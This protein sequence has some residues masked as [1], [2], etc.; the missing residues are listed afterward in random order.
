MCMRRK[1]PAIVVLL[2]GLLPSA[3]H[4]QAVR[5]IQPVCQKAFGADL[6]VSGKMSGVRVVEID[7]LVPM[8]AITSVPKQTEM[9]WPPPE[10]AVVALPAELS[11]ATGIQS[12]TFYWES[13]GHPPAPFMTPHFDFHFN[14][15]SESD[16]KSL[17]CSD[18][19]KPAKLPAGYALT[20]DTVPDIGVLVGTCVPL[21][22]MHALAMK[23]QPTPFTAT[24]VLGYYH[25]R[26]IFFEPMISRAML[27]SKKSFS[28]PINAV[29]DG[30]VRY[31]TMF[32]ARYDVNAKAY[33]FAL[34][35]F[36]VPKENRQ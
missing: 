10:D 15:I 16:R 34:T 22:G 24:M 5:S 31:P 23:G 11:A 27:L 32:N 9:K 4:G 2:T 30:S 6:C 26:P 1:L 3:L 36:K 35:G 29:A 14:T 7:A 28:L 33:R 12:L 21:M 17:D 20:D 18:H 13:M 25:G 8:A 19:V